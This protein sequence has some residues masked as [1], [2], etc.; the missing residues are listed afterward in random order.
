MRT[1]LDGEVDARVVAGAPDPA[2]WADIPFL[3][4]GL[5]RTSVLRAYAARAPYLLEVSARRHLLEAQ[6]DAVVL[7]AR[8]EIVLGFDGE[9]RVRA[10]YR[11]FNRASQFLPLRLPEG[12]VLFGAVAAGVPIKPLAGADGAILLPVPKVPLGGAGY[13]VS[14]T[15]RARAGRGFAG[16]GSATVLLPHVVGV[17]VDRTVITLRVPEG[18]DYDFDTKMS[19]ATEGEALGDD[20][21]ATI[22]EAEEVLKVAETGTL[23]QRLFACSNSSPLVDQARSR[24]VLYRRQGARADRAATLEAELAKLARV[25]TEAAT[26]C[27]LDMGVARNEA[28]LESYAARTSNS[29]NGQSLVALLDVT[30]GTTVGSAAPGRDGPSATQPGANWLFN[31]ATV[32]LERAKNKELVELKERLQSELVR[33]GVEDREK[34]EMPSQES[35]GVQTEGD[36]T[37][38][39]A[40]K[41]QERDAAARSDNTRNNVQLNDRLRMVQSAHRQLGTDA[42]DEVTRRVATPELGVR[43]SDGFFAGRGGDAGRST[44]PPD[45]HAGLMGVDVPLPTDGLVYWFVSARAGAA[46]SIEATPTGTPWWRRALVFAALGGAMAFGLRVVVRRRAARAA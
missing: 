20:V 30:S 14:V 19:V 13:E 11:L 34:S 22:R 24:L 42:G 32:P 18:F 17:E 21:E 33:R 39:R 10:R 7:S 36:P 12:A 28:Q 3:P 25:Q 4:A 2:E 23:E 6:A 15:Y 37:S 27:S 8:A 35:M 45:T 16:G 44:R 26:R 5:V 46:V 41:P 40:F 9:A 1:F 38:G 31:A 29:F 43:S